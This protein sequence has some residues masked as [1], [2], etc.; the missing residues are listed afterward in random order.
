MKYVSILIVPVTVVIDRIIKISAQSL[1]LHR[2]VGFLTFTYLHNYGATMGILQGHRLFLVLVGTIA[3]TVLAVGW[4]RFKV[5]SGLFWLG[6]ALLMGGAVGNLWDRVIY[7]YVIDMLRIP[8]YPA[9]F[10]VAD[11]AIRMGIIMML[12]GYWIRARQM[13]RRIPETSEARKNTNDVIN[14]S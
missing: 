14:D 9:V 13:S 11:V 10:N 4:F 8:V 5:S 3:V 2:P 12:I 7:G 6:W 1:I